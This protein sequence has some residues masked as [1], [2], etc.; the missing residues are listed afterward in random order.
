MSTTFERVAFLLDLD[1]TL[2]DSSQL[3][4]QIANHVRKVRG[5]QILTEAE[6]FSRIGLP[7]SSLF[8]DLCLSQSELH[9]CVE[10]FRMQF[11]NANPSDTKF[12]PG[13]LEFLDEAKKLGILISTAT[14]RPTEMAKF[15]LAEMGIAHYFDLIQGTDNFP[16]KPSPDVILR[17]RTVLG[18]SDVFMF[19]DRIEDMSA[20]ISAEVTAIG[21]EQ[22]THNKNDLIAAGAHEV[23][24]SFLEIPK[25]ELLVTKYL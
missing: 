20:A 22:T 4:A 13:S 9:V 5:Y 6:L 14:T 17:A 25:P 19:G 2:L 3:I 12:Y 18:A 1:G 24:S 7:A 23:Y 21:I 16:P 11:R 15:Q 10:V 8:Q